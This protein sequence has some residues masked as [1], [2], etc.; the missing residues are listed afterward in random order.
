MNTVRF[1][2]IA[3]TTDAKRPAEAV[4]RSEGLKR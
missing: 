2:R 3:L 4:E 1:R